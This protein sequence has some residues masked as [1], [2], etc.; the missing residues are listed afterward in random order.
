MRA[1]VDTSVVLRIVFSEKNR[2]KI[3]QKLEFMIANEILK[4]ECFRTLDRMRHML[5]LT[6]NDVAMRSVLLYKALRAIRFI[7]INNFI[8]ERAR[9]PFPTLVKSLDAIHLATA[10]EWQSQ[11]GRPLTFLT[12]DAQLGRAAEAV[13]I[14]V[15]GL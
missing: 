3:D 5:P 13:G 6:D 9:Q 8:S 15:L 11:D 12:H 7:K 4:I 2:L 10:L 1:Y 14:E